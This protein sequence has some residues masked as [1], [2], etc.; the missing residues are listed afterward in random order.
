MK[1]GAIIW[2]F[3]DLVWH[4]MHIVL[5]VIV[6]PHPHLFWIYFAW[7]CV[8]IIMDTLLIV[9]SD[10]ANPVQIVMNNTCFPYLVS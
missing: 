5:L 6:A 3:I 8:M 4:V 7:Y 9:E 1:Q 10:N 2:G